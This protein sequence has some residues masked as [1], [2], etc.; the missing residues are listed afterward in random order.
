MKSL[1]VSKW[2]WRSPHCLPLPTRI[3]YTLFTESKG[4]GKR[5]AQDSSGV[6]G[7]IAEPTG[8]DGHRTTGRTF[9]SFLLQSCSQAE[10]IC[11]S[12]STQPMTS[13][14]G[15]AAQLQTHTGKFP[16]RSGLPF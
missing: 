13:P 10:V 8:T 2:L 11:L 4:R 12:T 5:H 1:L 16:L 14:M 7:M 6:L 3:S 9:T 15:N